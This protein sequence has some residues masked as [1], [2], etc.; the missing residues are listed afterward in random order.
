MDGWNGAP[1]ASDPPVSPRVAGRGTGRLADL[2]CFSHLRWDFVFQRPQHLM[3]R[4][5]QSVGYSFGKNRSGSNRK[6]GTQRCRNCDC[7]LCTGV[8]V[9]TPLLSAGMDEPVAMK[10]QRALLDRLVRTEVITDPVLWYYTP[11]ALGFSHHLT[12]ER[13]I[14]YDC[15]DELSAFLGADPSLPGRERAL[16]DR[17]D[18]VFTGGFSL[19]EVKRHQHGNVHPFP[20]GVDL[21]HFRPARGG[22]RNQRINARSRICGSVSTA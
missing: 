15:M 7:S 5:A 9:A 4:A 12:S 18:I 6:S 13:P 21:A 20:S 19:Y 11:Q 8:V 10:A 2:I 17:A 3:T 14:V 1:A 16:M 22:L